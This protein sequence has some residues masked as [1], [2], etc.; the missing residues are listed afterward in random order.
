MEGLAPDQGTFI[1]NPGCRAALCL[2][3]GLGQ[4]SVSLFRVKKVL[5]SLK[6]KKKKRSSGFRGIAIMANLPRVTLF[7]ARG[8]SGRKVFLGFKAI[9]VKGNLRFERYLVPSAV[10]KGWFLAE[11]C[12]FMVCICTAEASWVMLWLNNK[13][14]VLHA[15]THGCSSFVF[16]PKLYWFRAASI[17]GETEGKGQIK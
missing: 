17:S 2:A 14:M 5:C 4:P 11:K 3:Q 6:K 9:Q 7:G 8:Y 15:V 10:G 1:T 16:F 12:Y 13:Q